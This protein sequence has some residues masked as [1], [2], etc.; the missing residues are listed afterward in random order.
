MKAKLIATCVCA[1][2]MAVPNCPATEAP[3]EEAPMYGE[4]AAAAV[5]QIKAHMK[6]VHQLLT[7]IHDASTAATNAPLIEAALEGI[8]ATDVSSFA[9]EDEECLAAE[10]T[11]DFTAII[12]EVDRLVKAKLY[13]DPILKKLFGHYM[14][15]Q[16]EE[17]MPVQLT[18]V[19]EYMMLTE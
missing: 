2:I 6:T 14:E 9:N 19:T 1:A 12:A 15:S 18:P 3:Q 10:F 4:A 8:K 13:N 7:G 16:D 5:A 17:A 11:D